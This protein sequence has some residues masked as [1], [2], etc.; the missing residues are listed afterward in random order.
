MSDVAYRCVLKKAP[1]LQVAGK[2]NVLVEPAFRACVR[3]QLSRTWW[4]SVF[5]I[6]AEAAAQRRNLG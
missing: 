2:V 5:D 4:K 1:L 6:A 3:T